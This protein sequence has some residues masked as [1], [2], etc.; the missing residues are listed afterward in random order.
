MRKVGLLLAAIGVAVIAVSC[1]GAAQTSVTTTGTLTKGY[2]VFG[3]GTTTVLAVPEVIDATLQAGADMCAKINASW[4]ILEALG[5]LGGVVDARGFNGTQTCAGSMW[6][7]VTSGFAATLLTAGVNIQTSVSQVRPSNT[8]WYSYGHAT[9]TPYANIGT[10]L[11][12]SNSFPTNTP[13]EQW[14]TTTVSN[15]QDHNIR[16]SCLTPSGTPITGSIGVQNKWAQE[17]ST[18][19]NVTIDGC[20][21]AGLDI[22]TSN[23]QNS[24]PYNVNI[25]ENAVTNS[26]A[27][28]I[29]IGNAAGSVLYPLRAISG[30]INGF[31]SSV[32]L[33]VG[34]AIDFA[35]GVNLTDIHCEQYVTCVEIGANHLTHGV[36]I[37]NLE[38]SSVSGMPITTCVDISAAGASESIVAEN[39]FAPAGAFVTNALADHL[40]NGCTIPVTTDQAVALYVRGG[41]NSVFAPGN[42]SCTNYFT[43]PIGTP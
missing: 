30:T 16:I 35:S 18:L 43:T 26:G 40:T 24:G 11:Q 3:N 19:D 28:G 27:V 39:I 37:V 5:T 8:S 22:E 15:I 17:G 31:G 4:T 23:S 6:S 21:N 13:I 29:R 42:T 1:T 7:N 20:M 32:E 34:I 25:S 10:S 14:G 33:N 38:C 12:P 41:G 2:P 9:T 36:H